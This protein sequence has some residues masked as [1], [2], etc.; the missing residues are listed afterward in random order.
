MA[1]LN[2]RQT[3]AVNAGETNQ[4]RP[5]TNAE[6]DANFINLNSDKLEKTGGTLTGLLTLRAGAAGTN[7]AP[8]RFQSGISLATPVTGA[9]EFDGTNLYFT[10]LG[11]R[12]TVAFTDGNI[13]GNAATA[14]AWQ[15]A[16]TVTL[17]G[18]VTGSA[19]F[20]GSTDF[21]IATTISA[22]ATVL[23]TDT[24]GNYVASITNGS[25]M[26]GGNGG[27]EGAALTLAV[28]ATSANT[29]SKVVARDA[30]GNFSAGTI[31]A[32]LSGNASTATAWQTARTL[33]LTG[34][35][36][37][38]SASFDGSGN[39]TIATTIS[40]DATVLGTDTTGNY[41]A[42]ITNG[43][44]ITGGN[45]GSEGAALTIAVDATSANTA[46]KVVARDASG[47]FAAGTITASLSGNASTVTNG[48]YTVGDQS[49]SGIKTFNSTIIG[50]IAGNAT[51]ATTLQTGRNIQ[52]VSFNGSGDITVVTAGT[53][54]SV[55]G[56]SV[57][58]GQAVATTSDVQFNNAR[59]YSLGAGL[60]APNIDGRI[61]AKQDVV[62]YASSDERLKKDIHNIPEA[63][64][65]VL[66]LNG[67]LFTW[68]EE[69][70]DVHGYTGQDT[71][72]IAQ[73][74]AAVLPEVV[75]TREDG[76]MAV[77]YE[78]MMGLLIEAIKELDAKVSACTCNK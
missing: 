49:I 8:L 51:T 55:S 16:R 6:V 63:L 15:T 46:S 35:V 73:Q 21:S 50:N 4:N 72:V 78:K 22:D 70:K 39:I 37:G 62:A 33:T 17:T 59:V 56:T 77:K 45:G 74:V 54:V 76:F 31:T 29:A 43:S 3:A 38:T 48:V 18:D 32:S 1:T 14:S 75:I 53:G 71:G 65:K 23:G 47:N 7:G 36:T 20:N 28:D 5:L 11:T 27:S 57:S 41:V 44:Y 2:L 67:V 60:A 68:D 12:K 9:M 52:G 30:S 13:T 58:I 40:G 34:D 26:T 10:P 24:T 69:K 25:F 42:S 19:T 61:E 64:E 66:K